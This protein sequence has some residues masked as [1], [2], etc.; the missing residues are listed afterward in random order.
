MSSKKG[1]VHLMGI[2]GTAMG[3][4]AGL[5][6]QMGYDVRGSDQNVYPPMSTK[7][8]ELGI[9]ILEGY[10]PEN[11]SPKPDKV[12]V[13]NVMSRTHSEVQ[14]LLNTDIPYMSLPQAMGEYLIR[15]R[16]SVVISGTHGKT[17]TTAL[18]AWVLQTAGLHPGFMVGGVPL[19]FANSFDVGTGSYFV[20]EGDEY[21]T[22]FFD[23][24]PK[25]THYRPRTSILTSIEFDHADIYKDLDAVKKAF[26]LLMKLLP[27]EG[28]LIYN[29]EDSNIESILSDCKAKVQ[30]YGVQKGD[31]QLRGIQWGKESSQFEVWFKGKREDTVSSTL[32]GEYNLL[33]S[34]AVYAMA[35]SLG[36]DKEKIKKGFETF[37]GVKRRQEIFAKPRDIT[38]IDDFAHHPT[39]VRVTIDGVKKRFKEAQVIGVFEPRSATSRRKIFQK[40]FAAALATADAV[41]VSEPYDQSKINE[42]DRFSSQELLTDILKLKP[43]LQATVCQS[44]GDI[45]STIKR[46]AKPGDVVLLMSNGGFGG[47]YEK[48]PKILS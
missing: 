31:W 18:A 28:T 19:N 8:R 17:T 6:K 12:I 30:G 7:L 45:M 3:S 41:I 1:L 21:D 2:C 16:H 48:L 27:P 10:R 26:Q 9:Q 13:G 40:E 46:W 24:V 32:F 44:V 29:A 33:N 42:G 43:H 25:F 5:L 39:A 15:D 34:L 22:A 20:I 14:A 36:I 4:L 23:K 38:L 37:K 11:L 47:I 35:R